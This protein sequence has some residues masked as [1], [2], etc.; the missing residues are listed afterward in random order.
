MPDLADTTADATAHTVAWVRQAAGER[1]GG[2]E[3]GVLAPL[4]AVTDDDP[5]PAADRLLQ[6]CGFGLASQLSVEQVLARP[7]ALIGG[8]EHVIE[9]LQARRQRDG[10]SDVV[11][12]AADAGSAASHMD[13][14]APVVARLAGR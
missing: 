9:M 13:A 2:T 10:L 4:I 6:A 12:R 11:I 7:P 5:R 14:L 3:L 1:F 8:V